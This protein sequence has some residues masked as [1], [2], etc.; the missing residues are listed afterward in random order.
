MMLSEIYKTNRAESQRKIGILNVSSIAKCYNA[1]V[2][3]EV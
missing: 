2:Y 3:D 1:G